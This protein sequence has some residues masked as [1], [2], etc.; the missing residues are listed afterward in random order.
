MPVT[1]E[2]DKAR[3][4]IRT[5]CRGN[6][7]LDDVLRHFRTLVEDPACPPRLDV[8]L[9][10]RELTSIPQT[11]ALRSVSDEM[12]RIQD[13]LRFDACAI[14]A[15]KEVGLGIARMFKAFAKAHFRV[16]R[17]FRS[18]DEADAW[19]REQQSVA[20]PQGI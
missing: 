15:S 1:Y 19:L 5:S 7:N 10:F 13:R 17:V 18:I 4:L 20:R 9:D 16:T 2:I 11:H 14:I 6:V 3:R 12:G 8:S